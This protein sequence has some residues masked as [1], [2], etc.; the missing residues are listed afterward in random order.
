M[1][2]NQENLQRSLKTLK[3]SLLSDYKD[4]PIFRRAFITKYMNFVF[5]RLVRQVNFV[6]LIIRWFLFV[7]KRTFTH[8]YKLS[9]SMERN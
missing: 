6:A 3:A 5:V 2:K 1:I 4:F 9:Q 7:W 8:S